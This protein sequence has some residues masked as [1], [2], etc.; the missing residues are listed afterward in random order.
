MARA[1]IAPLLVE[2]PRLHITPLAARVCRRRQGLL[3]TWTSVKHQIEQLT[4]AWGK[5][6][7]Q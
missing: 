5:K 6:D 2:F 7:V 3:I 4:N 1:R